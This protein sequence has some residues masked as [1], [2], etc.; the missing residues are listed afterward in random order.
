[1]CETQKH[2]ILLFFMHTTNKI[3]VPPTANVPS[4]AGNKLS[5]EELKESFSSIE[6]TNVADEEEPPGLYI[7]GGVEVLP[8]QS[9]NIIA[10]QKKSGKTNFAGLLMAAGASTERQVLGGLVRCAHE[11]IKVLVIDTEQPYKD[12]R[13]TL[14]RAMKTAGFGY[15]EQW[16]EHGINV[17]SFKNIDSLE[18]RRG[19]SDDKSGRM[20]PQW[21]WLAD[22]LDFYR[23]D[24]LIIDGIADLLKSINDE[25][26]A[27]ELMHLLDC[28][29][30]EN[31][32]AVIGMLHLNYNSGKI[33]GWA[34]TQA[35]KK[36]T[37]C[38]M[39]KKKNGYFEVKHEGRGAEVPQLRFRITCPS[40]DK[41][42]WWEAVGDNDIVVTCENQKRQELITAL[43]GAPLPCNNAM[44]VRWLMSKGPRPSESTANRILRQCR[45]Q[46]I[47]KSRREGRNSVWSWVTDDDEE[48]EE[49]D[50]ND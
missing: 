1:M 23:P 35:N 32:C 49:L 24:V 38:F 14:R 22:A 47:L 5:L 15:D 46:G 10:A 27:I 3:L 29:A 44:L 21:L 11:S 37:D 28:I 17:L 31:N 33:G 6:I 45:E 48:E 8:R 30:C 19:K 26:E 43:D 41:Y 42:G 12:A 9:V 25:A 50:F 18:E 13:R 34:G 20:R 36:F 40:G 4:E 2:F 39:L 7:I 16:S